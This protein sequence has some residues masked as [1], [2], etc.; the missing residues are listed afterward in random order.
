MGAQGGRW[1]AG[2]PLYCLW[3]ISTLPG[4]KKTPVNRRQQPQRR[5]PAPPMA[6]AE[7]P[8]L[9]R[10]LALLGLRLP[11]V[12]PPAYQYVPIVV[13]NGIAFISGQTTW[14]DGR[15]DPVG[16]VGAEVSLD[17]AK[18]GARQCALQA[19]AWLNHTLTGGL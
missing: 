1:G 17:Q 12:R 16:K 10:R 2:W 15:L 13:H 3:S 5:P 7:Q 19:L 18:D 9:R 6:P 14:V 4:P 11:E 8:M